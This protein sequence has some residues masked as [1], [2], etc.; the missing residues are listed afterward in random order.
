MNSQPHFWAVIPAAG[1]G[2]RMRADRPKQYLPLGGRTLLEHTL[3]CFLDHPG[4]R[5]LVLALGRDDPYWPTLACAD[6]PRI[7]RADGGAERADSVL[8]ALVKLEALGA[9]VDDWVLVHDAARPNLARSDLDRLLGELAD[10]PVGGLL[11]VPSRD[12]VKLAGVDG[13]VARTLDRQLIW[14][15]F[16]PQMFRLGALRQALE[17]GLASGAAITDEASAMELAGAAP[18]LIE[19][20]ADNLKVTRPED[21]EWLRLAWKQKC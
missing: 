11:A 3:D 9:S 12:T 18:R 7:Q 17:Q 21:L 13:K 8:N 1:V 20:R 19:G 15:A 4:L 14:L 2:A 5:G 16:T 10:D 6:D